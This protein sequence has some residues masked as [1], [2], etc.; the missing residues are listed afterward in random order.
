LCAGDEVLIVSSVIRLPI[1]L[2]Q[3][4]GPITFN[5]ITRIT[6]KEITLATPFVMA[7]CIYSK[8]ASPATCEALGLKVHL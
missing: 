4:S 2:S 6:P 1:T 3:I 8:G 5:H 7:F